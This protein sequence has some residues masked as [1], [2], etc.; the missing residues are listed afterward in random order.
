M[1][2]GTFPSALISSDKVMCIV[3]RST[4]FIWTPCWYW[5][6]KP[7][8]FILANCIQWCCD[9]VM[10]YQ[11]KYSSMSVCD[12][13]RTINLN[14]HSDFS[15]VSLVVSRVVTKI[16]VW[17]GQ[18]LSIVLRN[19][20]SAGEYVNV[21]LGTTLSVQIKSPLWIF[22]LLRYLTNQWSRAQ[23]VWYRKF[24]YTDYV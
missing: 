20:T 1:V 17:K 23:L 3:L 14:F 19:N 16:P 12:K 4:T 5:L 10:V 7:T 2:G 6:G 13:T 18:H 15:W 21:H 8:N 22:Y 9:M 24:C 11:S